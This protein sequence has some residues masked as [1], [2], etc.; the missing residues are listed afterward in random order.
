MAKRTR[1]SIS[2]SD[3]YTYEST[4]DM[5]A[6]VPNPED[7]AQQTASREELRDMAN[8]PLTNVEQELADKKDSRLSGKDSLGL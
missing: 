8:T 5:Q 7:V 6:V 1:A 2:A 3:D 4:G